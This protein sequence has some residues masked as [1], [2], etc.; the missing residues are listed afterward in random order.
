MSRKSLESRTYY[1]SKYWNIVSKDEGF[2]GLGTGLA[3]GAPAPHRTHMF[4]VWFCEYARKPHG[5]FHI[6][7]FVGTS[8]IILASILDVF[9]TKNV[10]KKSNSILH[11]RN[12]RGGKW[13][14]PKTL[15]PNQ[16]E[17]HT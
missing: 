11:G 16:M 6:V 8:V 15:V 12:T 9:A 3:G 7:S 14:A 5:T 2:Q 1:V 10:S 13:V 4:E 17:F